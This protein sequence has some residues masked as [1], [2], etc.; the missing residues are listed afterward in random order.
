MKSRKTFK[1]P[2]IS[3]SPAKA[4]APIAAG[5]A[6]AI[7]AAKAVPSAPTASKAFAP[8]AKVIP[9]KRSEAPKAVPAPAEKASVVASKPLETIISVKVDVGFGNQ[10]YLRGEGPGLS[11]E[12][13]VPADCAASDLWTL[14]LK[15]AAKPVRFK[16]LVNDA[17]WSTGE[18]YEVAPG[19][20]VTFT[21]AF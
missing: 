1:T 21:P 6:P 11:W 2:T 8:V 5:K 15:D 20:R 19:Q 17:T 18:D 16:V 14:A 3:A 10:V 7:S 9:V 12:K 13:G 4:P